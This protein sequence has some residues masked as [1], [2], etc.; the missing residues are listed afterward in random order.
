MGLT[1]L[2]S[3]FRGNDGSQ[4]SPPIKQKTRHLAGFLFLAARLQRYA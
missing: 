4:K 1:P 2:D 3:R